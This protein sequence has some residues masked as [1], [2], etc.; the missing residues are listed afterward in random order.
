MKE[1]NKKIDEMI[2]GTIQTLNEFREDLE[3]D[4][5]EPMIML[6][7]LHSHDGRDNVTN[8]GCVHGAPAYLVHLLYEHAGKL[9]RELQVALAARILKGDDD[10]E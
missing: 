4:V 3:N 2:V 1:E 7:G 8:F 10:D 6:L 9:P 5:E